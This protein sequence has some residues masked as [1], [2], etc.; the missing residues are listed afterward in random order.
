MDYCIYRQT[1][2]DQVFLGFTFSNV[3]LYYTYG[4]AIFDRGDGVWRYPNPYEWE[5]RPDLIY[6][7]FIF[8]L[9]GWLWRIGIPFAAQDQILRFLFGAGMIWLLWRLI[10][11][12]IPNP[13]FRRLAFVCASLS[14]GL[15][16]AIAAVSHFARGSGFFETFVKMDDPI[17]E[18]FYLWRQLFLSTETFYHCLAFGVFILLIQGRRAAALALLALTWCSH[19]FTGLQTGA[20]TSLFLTFALISPSRRHSDWGWWLGALGLNALACGY[21]GPFLDS[22]ESHRAMMQRWMWTALTVYWDE[23]AMSDG[24]WIAIGVFA[25]AFRRFRRWMTRTRPGRLWLSLLIVTAVLMSVER[26]PFMKQPSQPLHFARGYISLALIV[27]AAWS[28]RLITARLRWRPAAAG[29]ILAVALLSLTVPDNIL[30]LKKFYEIDMAKHRV[31][32]IPRADW[33]VIQ[34]FEKISSP[35]RIAVAQEHPEGGLDYLLPMFTPHTTALGHP[36]NT[37]N[38]EY[39]RKLLNA[40][41]RQDS[42]ELL[43]VFKPDYIVQPPGHPA[44]A[45]GQREWKKVFGNQGWNIFLRT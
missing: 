44:P 41:W 12:Q 38:Y 21:Y 37:T 1:G 3:P 18:W 15:A 6:G 28:L 27:A 7:Q 10:Q 30:Y 4:R 22:F 23:V 16:W 2:P 25:L 45:T 9:F 11:R 36:L 26:F 33:E 20:I 34:W 29:A 40:Y 39:K 32:L 5:R 14:G 24:L 17:S 19:P 13:A 35:Q 43:R 42:D 8:V 31:A